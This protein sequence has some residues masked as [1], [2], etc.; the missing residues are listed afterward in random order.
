MW[1]RFKAVL[2]WA[3]RQSS[4]QVGDR[5]SLSKI[6][7]QDLVGTVVE[8]PPQPDPGGPYVVELYAPAISE[9][10]AMNPFLKKI[11]ANGVYAS[12]LRLVDAGKDCGLTAVGRKGASMCS[13][14][15]AEIHALGCGQSAQGR[16]ARLGGLSARPDLE[17]LTG[18]VV[19][20][21]DPAG[22]FTVRVQLE[23]KELDTALV[24]AD[25]ITLRV[26]RSAL[27]E[28]VAN[29]TV[30][31][32]GAIGGGAVPFLSSVWHLDPRSREPSQA[33]SQEASSEDM[34]EEESELQNKTSTQRAS[35]QRP[36]RLVSL[37]PAA[38]AALV[39]SGQIVPGAASEASAVSM[40]TQEQEK[41]GTKEAEAAK[42]SRDRKFEALDAELALC[43]ETEH[44][45]S[46]IP[47]TQALGHPSAGLPVQPTSKKTSSSS[48][49]R[50]RSSSR[51]KSD[52]VRSDN[53]RV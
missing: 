26:R 5:V 33:G 19:G 30:G 1:S 27:P 31:Q 38:A 10:N 32:T 18:T 42:A 34:E 17:G 20:G 40:P 2:P 25:N 12:E 9:E 50:K 47:F 29:T 22:Q 14:P 43:C 4:Y 44:L 24:S 15:L 53:A 6:V 28:L 21:P 8:A 36:S 46:R 41:K 3:G 48:T 7:G 16:A 37:S 23:E 52:D 39:A 45:T 11:R 51:L 35:Q 49:R 13:V